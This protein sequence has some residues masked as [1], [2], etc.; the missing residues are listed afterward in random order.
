MNY[1]ELKKNANGK[2]III[3]IIRNRTLESLQS[4]KPQTRPYDIFSAEWKINIFRTASI[5]IAEKR[6]GM[7]K[8][9]ADPR[10]CNIYR[11]TASVQTENSG[12]CP[13]ATTMRVR[14]TLGEK[15]W[16]DEK[17]TRRTSILSRPP[18]AGKQSRGR[19]RREIKKNKSI[20][21][22]PGEI[23]AIRW[24]NKVNSRLDLLSRSRA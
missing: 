7:I 11:R 1:D 6:L 8:K 10:K 15:N 2:E 21:A 20:S 24:T 16:S 18:C 5:Y 17:T 22:G 3:F 13:F 12:A 14:V 4:G 9:T 19:R 23:D